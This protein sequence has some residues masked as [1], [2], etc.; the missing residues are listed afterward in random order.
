MEARATEVLELRKAEQETAARR[1][2]YAAVA[3][4]QE[5]QL[6]VNTARKATSYDS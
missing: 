1:V 3:E 5:E 6:Q 2:H 4:K